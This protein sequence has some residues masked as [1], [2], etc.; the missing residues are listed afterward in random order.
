MFRFVVPKYFLVSWIV[1]SGWLVNLEMVNL[2]DP[3]FGQIVALGYSIFWL[4]M[5]FGVQFM[6]TF[7]SALSTVPVLPATT[8]S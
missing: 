2:P 8:P 3:K 6:T 7:F 4:A 1:D 5:H